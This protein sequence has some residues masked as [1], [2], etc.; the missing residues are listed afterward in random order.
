M[1]DRRLGSG[2]KRSGEW[3]I[4]FTLIA[5]LL[6]GVWET[7]LHG[8]EPTLLYMSLDA[9]LFFRRFDL[10]NL[11]YTDP[12]TQS[13]PQAATK[14]DLRIL[15]GVLN[16]YAYGLTWITAGMTPAQINDQWLWGAD[17][18]F[19]RA[20]NH[21]PSDGLLFLGRWVS[22]L[23]TAVTICGVYAVGKRIGGVRAAILAAILF[24]LSPSVLLN[25]RRAMMES[26]FLLGTVLLLWVAVNYRGRWRWGLAFGFAAGLAVLGK[27][28]GVISILA[29]G[30]SLALWRGLLPLQQ[31]LHQR[32]QLAIGAI[33]AGIVAIVIFVAGNPAWWGAPLQMPK[34]VLD[35]RTALLTSQSTFFGSY[36]DLASRIEG[37]L[38]ETLIAT[39]Q[40][41]EAQEGWSTWLKESIMAYEG[42]GVAGVGGQWGFISISVIIGSIQAIRGSWRTRLV[43]T[44]GFLTLIAIFVTTPL[45]WQRYYLVIL[46]YTALVAGLAVSRLPKKNATAP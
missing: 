35:A 25:G 26:G 38:R 9:D 45:Y 33:L 42:G 6:I 13:D 3:L 5:Y 16:K 32:A 30:G 20:N 34:R 27:H 39:P 12:I 36:P 23:M 18:A 1:T 2:L 28:T 44:S 40:Y 11:V 14:Q 31:P 8:D 7:P 4:L 29:V 22:S 41:F 37:L 10:A 21:V 43:L 19:N 24:T 15:N 46:P 17:L